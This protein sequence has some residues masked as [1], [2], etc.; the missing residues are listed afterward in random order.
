M[1]HINKLERLE[2]EEHRADGRRHELKSRLELIAQDME[3]EREI[4]AD[5]DTILKRLA[6][7]ESELNTS[8][9]GGA[10]ER[11]NAAKLLQAAADTMD[12]ETV[13]RIIISQLHF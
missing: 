11:S 2:E 8:L 5:N 3:R 9:E 1:T 7:Q 4:I 6:G 13:Q 12:P 10:D